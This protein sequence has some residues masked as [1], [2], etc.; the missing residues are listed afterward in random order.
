MFREKPSG[1]SQTDYINKA[2]E[3]FQAIRKEHFNFEHCVP[4]LEDIPKFNLYVTPIHPG[5][6]LS[7]KSVNNTIAGLGSNVCCPISQ[8]KDKAIQRKNSSLT[9][10]SSEEAKIVFGSLVEVNV[11]I[12]QEMKEKNSIQEKDLML[13]NKWKLFSIF[14]EHGDERA[15]Q[16]L[17]ELMACVHGVSGGDECSNGSFDNKLGSLV[18]DNSINMDMGDSGSFDSDYK[19]RLKLES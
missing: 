14:E 15:E 12:Y 19:W 8:N 17:N 4:H 2:S 1:V 13:K 7:G 6:A 10:G 9:A 3:A 5:Q 18:G 16:I 11:K